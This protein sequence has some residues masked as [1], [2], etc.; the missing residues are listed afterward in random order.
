MDNAG[1]VPAIKIIMMVFML[2]PWRT[3]LGVDIAQT[4]NCNN[5]NI[6]KKN[7]SF[8]AP[9]VYMRP[10]NSHLKPCRRSRVI[11]LEYH[12]YFQKYMQIVYP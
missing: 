10:E 8:Q 6:C 7:V 12:F 11:F 9:V 5:H 4:Q 2:I 3:I 1:G